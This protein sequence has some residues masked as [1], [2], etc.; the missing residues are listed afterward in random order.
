M[1]KL[2]M[3]VIIILA[4]AMLFGSANAYTVNFDLGNDMIFS[5]LSGFQFDV[6]GAGDL[7]AIVGAPGPSMPVIAAGYPWFI[8]RAAND[9]F[10]SYDVSGA[11]S[12]PF[13]AG[14]V[15]VLTRDEPFTLSNFIF[16]SSLDQD[17][18]YPYTVYTAENIWSDGLGT[19]YTAS[20]NQMPPPVPIPAAVWLLGSGLLGLVAI[21]RRSAKA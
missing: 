18:K 16:S 17:G 12:M 4:V 10:F 2:L 5:E 14:T 7:G 20:L 13:S 8:G 19:T 3:T 11:I 1:K 6:N 21:R 15:M 9:G